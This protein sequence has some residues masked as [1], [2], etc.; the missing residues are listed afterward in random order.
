[1]TVTFLDGGDP[2][3]SAPLDANGMATFSYAGLP[4]GTHSITARFD[5]EGCV[6]GS[7][8]DPMTEQ[9]D[10]IPTSLTMT[11]DANPAKFGTKVTLIAERTPNGTITFYDGT[12]PLGTVQTGATS[13]TLSVTDFSTGKHDLTA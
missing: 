7:T 4:V 2:F 3:G 6:A 10:L 11:S 13:T 5:G 9:V 8:S 12:T 1:G